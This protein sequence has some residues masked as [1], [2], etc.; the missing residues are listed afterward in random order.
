MNAYSHSQRTRAFSITTVIVIIVVL[1]VIG[2]GVLWLSRAEGQE[3][4]G[5]GRP[6]LFIV[7]RGSFDITI[8][9]SGELAALNQVEI[10]N[11][12]ESRA[13][14]TYIVDEGINVKAGDILLRLNDEDISDRVKDAE[15]SVNTSQNSLVT[16]PSPW[17]SITTSSPLASAVMLSTIR[18]AAE[19]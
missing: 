15:D 10:R 17:F 13:A 14:I 3:N 2:G 5:N 4:N 19:M 1:V 18:S 16:A 12:L 6:D 9:A 11:K 8:P 7:K